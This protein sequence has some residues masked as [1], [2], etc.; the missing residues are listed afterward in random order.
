MAASEGI[1]RSKDL[2]CAEIPCGAD[3]ELALVASADKRLR[4]YPQS[5]RWVMRC[6]LCSEQSKAVCLLG[7]VSTAHRLARN[8]V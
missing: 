6:E 5:E 3:A 7:A 1:I 4:Y 2:A 8:V